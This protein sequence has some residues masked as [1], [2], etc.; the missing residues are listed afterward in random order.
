MNLVRRLNRYDLKEMK[1]EGQRE[2]N[3]LGETTAVFC[4]RGSEDDYGPYS[5]VVRKWREGLAPKDL[6]QKFHPD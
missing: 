3:R 1:V 5:Y 4:C 6:I 2:A